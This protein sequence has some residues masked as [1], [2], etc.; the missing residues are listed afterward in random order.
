MASQLSN[1]R[2]TLAWT[3]FGRPVNKPAPTADRPAAAAYTY[4]DYSLTYG[5]EHI[6]GT[7]P[8]R[9]RL[10]D[11]VKITIAFRIGPSWVARWVFDRSGT[12][13]ARLLH[14]EQGHY[15][16]VALLARDL[17]IDIMQLKE[18]TY[19]TAQAVRNA[20]NGINRRYGPK[21]QPV[22]NRYDTQSHHGLIQ[23]QQDRWDGFIHKAFTMERVP[24]VLAPDGTAYKCPLLT[25]LAAGGVH[26]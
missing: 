11:E 18:E 16:L 8:P 21:L 23:R 9:F 6:P 17:F 10:K 20:V 15:D 4:T 1:L 25:V 3:D 26:F 12:E 7:R 22:Q 24:R 5:P 2:K 14:H 19:R 13:Q